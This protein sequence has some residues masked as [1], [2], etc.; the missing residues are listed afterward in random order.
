M[1]L[2][3]PLA[4]S[5]E[6]STVPPAR[7]NSTPTA[8]T[9]TASRTANDPSTRTTPESLPCTSA[10]VS[11]D[12]ATALSAQTPVGATSTLHQDTLHQ[13]RLL[14]LAIA[15]AAGPLRL[16]A[17]AETF[18]HIDAHA[19][20]KERGRMADSAD[21][22]AGIMDVMTTVAGKGVRHPARQ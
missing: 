22:R 18:G 1:R 12:T 7:P 8:A 13:E 17:S 3:N 19:C 5:N 15:A 20:R 10:P 4:I 11:H 6:T 14:R 16:W 21:L 2:I 9:K